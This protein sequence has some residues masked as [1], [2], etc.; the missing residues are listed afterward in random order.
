MET[1]DLAVRFSPA[2]LFWNLSSGNPRPAH[3][4]NNYQTHLFVVY[5]LLHSRLGCAAADA[6]SVVVVDDEE[7]LMRTILMKSTLLLL[8]LPL[9][10]GAVL[11]KDTGRHTYVERG[12]ASWY[13]PGFHG[14]RTASGAQFDQGKLTA[15]HPELPFGTQVTVTN[16][17]NGKKVKVKINDRGP[18]AE[19]RIIDVSKEAAK[20][21]DMVSDGSAEVRIEANVRTSR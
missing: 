10:L 20:K 11:A 6:A 15:A 13:G 4:V 9:T 8:A 21:L 19:G 5:G 2:K 1:W 16:L 3:G 7:A 17:E 12:E 18:F 14:Q